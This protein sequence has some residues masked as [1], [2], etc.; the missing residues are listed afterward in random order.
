MRSKGFGIHLTAPISK[1]S[2]HFAGYLSVDDTDLLQVISALQKYEFAITSIQK[3][4]DTWEAGLKV[5]GGALVPE[6]NFWYL[7]DFVW[8]EGIWAYKTIQDAL[9]KIF[10]NDI[11]GQRIELK[12]VEPHIAEE[13]LGAFLAPT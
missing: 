5:T 4:V 3:A 1:T 9:G 2:V 8:K 10:A 7:I 11:L 13:T 6:K 12:R